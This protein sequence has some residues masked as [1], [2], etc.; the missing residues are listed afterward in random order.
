MN[1]L[2]IAGSDPSSGAGI[3]N[4]I[5]T[6]SALGAYGLCVITAVT[7]Q[8]TKRFSLV[9]QIS[10]KMIKDQLESIMSD[11][12][13][14]AIKIGM[15]YS[16]DAIKIIYDTCKK[17]K[18][19]IILDPVIESTTGGTLLQTNAIND[20]KKFLIPISHAIT[21]NVS[22]AEIIS[23][24]EIRTKTDA[25]KA[26]KKIQNLGA[27][28][29]IITG[30]VEGNNVIDFVL[31]GSKFYSFKARKIPIKNHGSGCTFSAS[32]AVF[33][34][35]RNSLSVSVKMAKEFATSS[36]RYSQKIGRGISIV[37]TQKD[38]IKKV[39]QVEISNF[40]RINSSYK[41]I[42]EI[43]TNFVYAKQNQKISKT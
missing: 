27:K 29:V 14:A 21:P 1:I 6:F 15:V 39:L 22:E 12:D 11:F 30:F 26:A 28:N 18:V 3:Q 31:D 42:P 43:G 37:S 34:A 5:K 9:E 7:S 41:L 36:I 4:D 32:L 17:T 25:I 24:V 38:E 2:S 35:A 19:S 10:P 40:A 23:G 33:L 16:S 20:F 8:N 13:I